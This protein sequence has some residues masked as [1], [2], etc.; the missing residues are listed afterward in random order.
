[1]SD[2]WLLVELG[3]SHVWDWRGYD[4]LLFLAALCLPFSARQWKSLLWLITCFTIGHSLSLVLASL[5]V[6]KVSSTWIEFLIPMS[7]AAT[8]VYNMIY[9]QRVW[10][11]SNRLVLWVTLF[12]GLVHGF[13]FAGYFELIRDVEQPLWSSLLFF[14]LGIEGAQIVLGA[15]M[16]LLSF[17]VLS[18]LGRNRRDWVLVVSSVIIGILLPIIIERWP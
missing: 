9:A 13:G 2:F 15:L 12:F 17:V 6:V 4:H 10:V 11:R 3:F 8:A 5:E 16:L 7:I 18:V 14:A 1:M